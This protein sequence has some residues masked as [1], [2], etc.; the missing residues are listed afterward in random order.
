[1][2]FKKYMILKIERQILPNTFL[3]L[4]LINYILKSLIYMMGQ[5]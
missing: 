4:R 1:M 3:K 2:H 5:G